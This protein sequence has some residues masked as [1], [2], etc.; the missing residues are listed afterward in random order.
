MP[1]DLY[2]FQAQI[3]MQSRG[4][5]VSQLMQARHQHH[6]RTKTISF[7]TTTCGLMVFKNVGSTKTDKDPYS[8]HTTQSL[9]ESLP[10]KGVPHSGSKL[11][12]HAPNTAVTQQQAA[13]RDCAQTV[14]L[15]SRNPL[16]GCSPA[17][18]G[19]LLAADAENVL[20][21]RLQR[22]IRGY[23]QPRLFRG[24]CG[25]MGSPATKASRL[26]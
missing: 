25:R 1:S 14:M 11:I 13:T 18:T 8:S 9:D 15:L 7:A 16:S 20:F 5:A 21:S 4:S 17:L 2:G 10:P 12:H 3:K 22:K 24:F 19:M 26:N 6:I 23:S